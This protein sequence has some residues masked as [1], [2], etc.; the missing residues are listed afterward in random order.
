MYGGRESG[1]E[2]NRDACAVEF[3]SHWTAELPKQPLRS[4]IIQK[5]FLPVIELRI[6]LIQKL[7]SL[8]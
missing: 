1:K 5:D 3:E 2:S 4:T 8:R 7:T 6:N